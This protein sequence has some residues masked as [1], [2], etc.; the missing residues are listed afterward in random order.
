MKKSFLFGF[1]CSLIS[2]F[3]IGGCADK[4]KVSEKQ[5]SINSP[6]QTGLSEVRLSPKILS[7]LE[8]DNST[9]KREALFREIPVPGNVVQDTNKATFVFSTHSGV[10][11]KIFTRI[12]DTV[13][14]RQP[15]LQ[16]GKMTIRAP[17]SGTVISINASEGMPI[18]ILDSLVTLADIDTIRV[19]FDVY[20]KEISQV[21]LGQKVEV[22]S[23]GYGEMIFPGTIQYISPNL[24]EKSQTLKVAAEVEN[25]NHHLKFG[26]FV[27]GKILVRS[28]QKVLVVPEEAVVQIGESPVVFI[29]QE[30]A[31]FLKKPVKIGRHGRGKMEILE[32]L[33]EGEK[34]VTKGSF[35]LKSESLKQNW[36]EGETKKR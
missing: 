33:N 9:V 6:L 16:V 8:I 2:L 13:Q 35:I 32:G 12:G 4:E 31:V 3:L 18:G 25:R 22:T 15:L 30:E 36:K 23:T 20:P 28:D 17:R 14:A 11:E 24:D 10:V 29:P 1:L 21:R 26:M 34:V 7:T 5:V 27:Q 19:V